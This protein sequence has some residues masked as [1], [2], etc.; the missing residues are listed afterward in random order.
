MTKC[1][2]CGKEIVKDKTLCER[3]FKI[4][5]YN[6]YEVVAKTNEDFLPILEKINETKDLVVLVCDLFMI[7]DL[8]F[9]RKYLTNDI[10]LVLTKRDVLPKSIYEEK[11]LQY[12]YGI[13]AVDKI[14]VSSKKNYQFDDLIAMIRNYQ[15]S[16]NVYIVGYTNVGKSTLVNK[17]IYNYSNNPYEI[18]TS[19]LPSTTL[20]QIEVEMD[21]T[22]TLIDTPGLLEEGSMLAYVSGKELKEIVPNKEIKPRTYQV[23]E[24]QY[25]LLGSYALVEVENLDIT[26][27]LANT[28]EIKR[29]Y[30]KITSIYEKKDIKVNNND[31]VIKGLGFIKTKQTGMIT[32]YTKKEVEIFTRPSLI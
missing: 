26:F 3:C 24:K 17:L 21:N 1:I 13:D 4:R 27:F 11:L 9:F 29:Y 5:H 16:K 8:S 6:E 7:G 12:S 30:K 25:F 31:V 19:P 10:L 23:K 20:N 28:I 32:I 18:T 15:K 14:I 2:G 22:L